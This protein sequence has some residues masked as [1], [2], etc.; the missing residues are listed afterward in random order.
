MV[1]SMFGMLA[2]RTIGI[3]VL[4]ISNLVSEASDGSL[5]VKVVGQYCYTRGGSAR[6]L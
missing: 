1:N 5:S 3:V 2:C 6:P 4:A